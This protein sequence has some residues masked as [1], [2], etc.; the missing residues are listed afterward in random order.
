MM[1]ERQ[2]PDMASIRLTRGNQGIDGR[3]GT[4]WF[5]PRCEHSGLIRHDG[6]VDVSTV[7]NGIKTHH[8]KANDCTVDFRELRIFLLD[9]LD[10]Y[11]IQ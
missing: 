2:T 4:V 5:C 1:T 11:T 3:T 7:L 6:G 8:W 9:M 10:T